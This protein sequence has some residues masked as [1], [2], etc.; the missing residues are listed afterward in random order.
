MDI[1][2]MNSR[3]G[4]IFAPHR[5]L[6]NLPGKIK[7]KRSH[8]YIT[9]ILV[10]TMHGKI[11]KKSCERNKFKISGQT[12]NGKFDLPIYHILCQVFKIILSIL[13]KNMEQQLIILQ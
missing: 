2:F 8:K 10:C 11:F 4:K 5:L 7:L 6:L 13:S 1:I 12:W 3:N 9:Q